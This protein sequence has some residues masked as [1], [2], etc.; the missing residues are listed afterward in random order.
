MRF[1]LYQEVCERIRDRCDILINLTTG[2]G[3][4]LLHN[5]KGA[6]SPWDTSGLKGPKEGVE[7][8]LRLK[9][10]LCSLDVGTLNLGSR[11]FV[12]LVGNV[13]KMAALIREAGVKPELEVFEIGHIR[14]AKH[15]IRQGLVGKP[16]LFQLRLGVPWEAEATVE[17]LVYMLS[18]LP[19]D[20]LWSAFGIGQHHFTIAT[21]STVRGGHVCVGF[22]ENFLSRRTC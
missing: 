4:C 6:E 5:P 9:P 18:N 13:E 11:V 7:H 16:P 19:S 12:N 15:L 20:A 22:E 21:V 1:D 14:I 10:E 17:N 8:V 3:G 2:A